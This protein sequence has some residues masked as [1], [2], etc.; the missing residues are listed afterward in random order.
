[1]KKVVFGITGLTVGG[2]ERVLIDLANKLVDDENYEISIFTLYEKGA[3]EKELD[4]R[5]KRISLYDFAYNEKSK[6]KKI[7]I[8]CNVLFNRKRIYKKYI[9]NKFDVE[10][11]FLEG[12]ITRIFSTKNKNKNIKKVAWIHNDIQ[13]VFGLNLKS[14]IKR[15]IDRNIYERFN[16]IIFVSNDN[17]D[18]FNR[19]YDDMALPYERVV[20]N[21][22]DKNRIKELS[23]DKDGV[24]DASKI[25]DDDEINIVQVSRLVPQ[26]NVERLVE[27][28]KE[29]IDKGYKHH[30]YILGDGPERARIEK[31]IKELK[32]EDTFTLLGQKV[33][34]YPYIKKADY[35][36]LFSNFE[37]W[38]MVVEEAKILNK[39]ILVTDTAVREV[40]ADYKEYSKIAENSKEGIVRLLEDAIKNYKHYLGIKVNYEYDDS[41]IIDKVKKQIDV[42]EETKDF[43]KKNVEKIEGKDYS[44]KNNKILSKKDKEEIKNTKKELKQRIKTNKTKNRRG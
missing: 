13:K 22:I 41:K 24:K 42:M 8:V 30:I 7:Q 3:L 23:K 25:F 14:K 19:V 38:P 37:G 18:S 9:K 43:Y 29:V 2:A 35:F 33:N 15:I 11:A 26:K 40:I 36:S 12:P 10:I 32:V 39:F 21:Y 27:A 20:Q 44:L 6:F 34:P 28:H 4:K 16:T 17:M 1:M 31:R 5:V